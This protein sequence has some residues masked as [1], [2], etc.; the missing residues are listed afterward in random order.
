MFEQAFTNID[1]V[2]WK[3]AGCSTDYKVHLTAMQQT[4]DAENSDLF[5][6]LAHIAYAMLPLTRRERS[7]NARTNILARFNT[8]QQNFVDFV[9][10]H[11]VNI[12]VEE[13]DQIM[14]TPLFQLKYH[15]SISGTIGD[16]GRPEEIGQ[17]F[18]GFQRYVYKA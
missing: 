7:D 18:A 6:V 16:L 2:L 4:L 11:Y 5:D 1:D 9:L 8:K 15:D 13:L 10:S 12:G 3:E 14:L 17:V